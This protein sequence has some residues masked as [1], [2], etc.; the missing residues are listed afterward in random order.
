MKKN[1]DTTYNSKLHDY[2]RFCKNLVQALEH[3]LNERAIPFLSINYRIKNIDSIKEKIQRK[4]YKNAFEEIEDICGLRI[5]CYYLSDIDRISEI[6]STEFKVLEQ[7]DKSDLLGEKEFGYRSNHFIIKINSDWTS[8]P[9]YRG[10]ETY[11]AEIQVRTVL[12]HAW[13]EIEHKLNYKSSQ[14]TPEMF[15]RKLYRLSAKFEEA[16]EQF[17][18]LKNNIT[19]YKSEIKEVIQGSTENTKFDIEFNLETLTSFLDF[20]RA[21]YPIKSI[22][23]PNELFDSF[24]KFE[25]TFEQLDKASDYALQHDKKIIEILSKN[26]YDPTGGF[27]FIELLYFSLDILYP[28]FY[29]KR[30]PDAKDW[31]KS[32]SEWRK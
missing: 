12:M 27:D 14:Q 17:E 5:I 30:N 24:K 3:F 31:K 1:I 21:E 13:A 20:K 8:A 11:K 2:E 26:G 29:K 18:D 32:V 7:Q 28:D 23:R 16:D 25:I 6:I 15:R 9:N 10:L 4:G 22:N 19:T